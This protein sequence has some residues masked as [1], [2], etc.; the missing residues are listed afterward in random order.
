MTG[1]GQRVEGHRVLRG[2]GN[3]EEPGGGAGGDDQLVVSSAVPSARVTRCASTS[4]ETA[5][6]VA[7][8]DV[9]IVAEDG[10]NGIGDVG[11]IQPGRGH[12]VEQ[13]L[14]G[15]EVVLVDEGDVHRL[16]PAG[17]WPPLSPAKPA[18]IDDDAGHCLRLTRPG[19]GSPDR[20]PVPGSDSW[21]GPEPRRRCL[22]PGAGWRAPGWARRP[23][24]CRWR[25]RGHGRVEGPEAV[26]GNPG[27]DFGA[28]PGGEGVLVDDEEPPGARD[29]A[30]HEVVVP[31]RD[32][33]Q[34]DDL[35]R[36]ILRREL[37]GRHER[38]VHGGAPGDD[39]EVVP[40]R[41]TAPRPK[42]S[43][44]PGGG[45]GSAA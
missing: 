30:A 31:R 37:L 23:R 17:A 33:A 45:I 21:P 8:H 14:E 34:V 28:E 44:H 6:A 2:A 41:A 36:A 1:V 26:L 39:G 5:P 32:R 24:R 22:R 29:R 35:H 38:L 3:G 19:A 27:G 40:R 11:G 12:L 25:R 20:A 18:P 9:G 13:R 7:E 15:V 42:G 16:V 43:T 4:T 10:A